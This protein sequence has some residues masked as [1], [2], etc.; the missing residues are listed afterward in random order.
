MKPIRTVGIIGNSSKAAAVPTTCRLI[1]RLTA[2][3]ITVR[4][5]PELAGCLDKKQASYETVS[6][7][8][9]LSSSDLVLVLGGDGTLLHAVRSLDGGTVPILGINLGSLGFLSEVSSAEIDPA[10]DAVL[11]GEYGILERPL[12]RARI[13]DVSGNLMRE[14]IALNDIVI[15]E[16]SL[17]RRAVRLEMFLG[18]QE[19]GRVVGD[20]VIVATPAGSTAYNLSAG[21]PI[22]SPGVHSFVLTAIC[23][24]TMSFRPLVYP[25]TETLV[26]QDVRTGLQVKVTAD[27]QVHSPVP[28]GGRVHIVTDPDRRA[29]FVTLSRQ[30]YFDVL[31]SKLRM[32]GGA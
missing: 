23:P 27:G 11:N 4:V 18:D 15:D 9:E 24:H 28:E 3:A 31:R 22:L 2:A 7:I 21:G 13:E 5:A 8:S 14:L 16:G 6:R 12:L 29:H 32:G 1:E 20:G 17:T 30:T 19:I 25:E 26:V 10:I